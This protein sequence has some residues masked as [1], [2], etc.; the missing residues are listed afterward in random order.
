MSNV[1]QTTIAHQFT[2]I[3]FSMLV[4]FHEDVFPDEDLVT[5][6]MDQ[7]GSNDVLAYL[8]IIMMIIGRKF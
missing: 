1:V 5:I 3:E 2:L 4:K 7:I 8:Y 6:F